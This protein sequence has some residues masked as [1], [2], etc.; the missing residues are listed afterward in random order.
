MFDSL[1]SVNRE[2]DTQTD[3]PQSIN[4]CGNC[5]PQGQCRNLKLNNCTLKAKHSEF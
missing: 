4:Q 5:A 1:P 3:K 2:P